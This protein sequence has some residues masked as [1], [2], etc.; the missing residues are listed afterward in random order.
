[1]E[2]GK[3]HGFESSWT[4]DEDHA[5]AIRSE[6]SVLITSEHRDE[7]RECARSIHI[8]GP[9]RSGPFVEFHCGLSC[10]VRA[11]QRSIIGMDD[12]LA[13]DVR[14]RFREASEGT[15]FLDC[16][17]MMSDGVQARLMSLLDE[18]VL[19]RDGSALHSRSDPRIVAGAS[20]SLLA[21]VSAGTFNGALFYRLNLIHLDFT[22]GYQGGDLMK[23]KDLMSTPPRTCRSDGDL[24]TIAQVMWDH[25]C[26]F[27]P[28]IDAF[29]KVVGVITDRDI[30]IA[31]AT[32]H[33]LP[34]SISA[35]ETITGRV[36]ACMADDSISDALATMKEFK[37]R[38]LAVI[39][40]TGQLQGVISINDIVLASDQKRKPTPGDVVSAMAAICAHRTVE[41][42]AASGV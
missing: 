8:E 6:V 29:G 7:R 38:R 27:V 16:V 24:G 9:R 37:V 31:T 28:L 14:H 26:G 3:R 20:R 2:T 22:N 17:E 32:R 21:A 34:E 23:V 18:K 19:H 30:C 35:A 39:D 11:G 12:D 36:H 33:R 40:A 25:D 13:S 10:G 4:N 5:L 42:I 1:M 15:L 41:T